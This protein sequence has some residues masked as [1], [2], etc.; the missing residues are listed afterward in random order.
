MKNYL[1]AICPDYRIIYIFLLKHKCQLSFNELLNDALRT[2][3]VILAFEEHYQNIGCQVCKVPSRTIS[4]RGQLQKSPRKSSRWDFFPEPDGITEHEM[5]ATTNNFFF[6]KKEW[7]EKARYV[8]SNVWVLSFEPA[9]NP[10]IICATR[11]VP[12]VG[13]G[14]AEARTRADLYFIHTHSNVSAM[15]EIIFSAISIQSP[16]FS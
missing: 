13:S 16:H 12:R 10:N 3:E 8:L 2:S 4:G 7:P 9:P 14:R 1:F 5:S 11:P 6:A 15:Q